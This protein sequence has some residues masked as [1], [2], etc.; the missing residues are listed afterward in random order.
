MQSLSL[1]HSFICCKSPCLAQ[2][3]GLGLVHKS[4]QVLSGLGH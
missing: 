3:W 4:G 2:G 1:I